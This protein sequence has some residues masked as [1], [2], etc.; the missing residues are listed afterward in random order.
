MIRVEGLWR[1]Y[2]MGDDELHA[3]RGVDETIEHGEYV[4]IM[5]P[6]GSG[7]STLL[8]VLGC[9]DLSLIHI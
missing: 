8:N 1:T 4:A 3:L 6:S 7:K 9:L 2:T 5:G